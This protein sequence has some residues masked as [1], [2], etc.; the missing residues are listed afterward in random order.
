MEHYEL[1]SGRN[2]DVELLDG[3]ENLMSPFAKES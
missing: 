1:K 2:A 3:G